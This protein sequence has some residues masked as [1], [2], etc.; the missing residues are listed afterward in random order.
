LTLP[1][2]G[3]SVNQL[4]VTDSPCSVPRSPVVRDDHD[5]AYRVIDDLAAHRAKQQMRESTATARPND[6]QVGISRSSDEF[7]DDEAAYGTDLHRGWPGITEP[8]GCP[9]RQFLGPLAQFLLQD[10]VGWAGHRDA[11]PVALRD[12]V[13]SQDGE[14]GMQGSRFSHRPVKRAFGVG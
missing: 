6:Y 14:R 12:L 3:L 10:R 2:T 7:P 11:A 8:A 5:W 13:H 9:L 1:F 4:A